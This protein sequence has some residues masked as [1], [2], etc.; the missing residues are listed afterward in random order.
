MAL[1]SL[2][3]KVVKVGEK[4]NSDLNITSLTKQIPMIQHTDCVFAVGRR[5]ERMESWE[6]RR[7]LTSWTTWIQII[8]CSREMEL[9][10]GFWRISV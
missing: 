6:L 2:A 1:L 4:Y 7:E 10:N 9:E 8:Y 3:D 5:I